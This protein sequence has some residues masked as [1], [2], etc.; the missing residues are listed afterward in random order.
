MHLQSFHFVRAEN[1]FLNS[2]TLPQISHDQKSA[3]FAKSACGKIPDLLETGT[4]P[5]PKRN[6]LRSDFEGETKR[7]VL[8]QNQATA[9]NRQKI[10][11]VGRC[12]AAPAT[13]EREY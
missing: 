11:V 7:R 13:E 3:H 9:S 6:T 4:I 12:C 8:A 10:V 5:M 1:S 2:K